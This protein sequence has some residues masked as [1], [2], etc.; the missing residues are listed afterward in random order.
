MGHT[1]ALK[2]KKDKTLKQWLVPKLRNI[3]SHWPNKNLALSL[4]KEKVL[5]GEYKNGNPMYKVMFRCYICD[6]LFDRMDVQV[7]HIESVIS[8]HGFED[9]N[10][11]IESLFCPADN[12]GCICKPCHQEKT[13]LERL[14]RKNFKK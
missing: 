3:S 8:I 1:L 5:V 2:T 11:Y 13:N 4:A 6:D 10:V 14:E 9:W 7:D 12:L